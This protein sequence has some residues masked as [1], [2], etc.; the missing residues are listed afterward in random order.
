MGKKSGDR[1]ENKKKVSVRKMEKSNG[2]ERKGGGGGERKNGEKRMKEKGMKKKKRKTFTDHTQ[3]Q[4]SWILC[5]MMINTW[6]N[7]T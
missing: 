3:T 1:E 6:I 7:R 2:K 5:R 4:D